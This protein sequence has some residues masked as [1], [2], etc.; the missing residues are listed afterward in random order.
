M[1][2]LDNVSA[3]YG[4]FQALFGVSLEVRAGESVA[5]IGPNGAG[6]TTLLRLISK[7]IEPVQGAI[8]FEN[9]NLSRTPPHQ[10]VSRGIAHVPENRRLF[11]RLTVEENL[12]MGA[13]TSRKQFEQRKEVAYGLFPRLKE[14]KDQAAG[15]LSGGEQQMC[16]IGRALM[17][18][19]K[20]LLLDE[21]SAGLAPV[22]VQSIF[23][24]VRRICAEGYT[25]LIVEQNIRQVLKVVGR[26]YLLDAGKI[27][28]SGSSEEFVNSKQ[29]Q[30][31]Y[32]GL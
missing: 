32:L 3:G 25:V 8:V 6:K 5:V 20:L 17:S 28:L 24:L 1:L 16:A 21:P 29:I 30:K 13:F 23:E 31:A 27:M 26:A 9:E 19:P 11:P 22:V 4:G 7:L 10:V 18:G 12:R 14:R 2:S 15:T